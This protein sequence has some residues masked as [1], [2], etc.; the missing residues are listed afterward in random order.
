MCPG[1]VGTDQEAVDLRKRLTLNK[2]LSCMKTIGFEV[3][4]GKP[5]SKDELIDAWGMS[6]Q[7]ELQGDEVV[8]K[9]AGEDKTWGTR[10]DL[11]VACK[12]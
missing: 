9:S 8:V 4:R 5:P 1:R 12:R 6:M 3:G 11:E 10:D 7:I 2:L